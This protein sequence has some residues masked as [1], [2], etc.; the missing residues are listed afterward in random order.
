M[1][2]LTSTVAGSIGLGNAGE[3]NAYTV[4]ST[5]Y[6]LFHPFAI[7]DLL[8]LPTLTMKPLQS[9][10]FTKNIQFDWDKLLCQSFYAHERL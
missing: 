8:R 2:T 6:K 7:G 10:R 4:S 1:I 3:V 5:G 9:Y